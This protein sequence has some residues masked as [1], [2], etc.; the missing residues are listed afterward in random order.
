MATRHCPSPECRLI[1]TLVLELITDYSREV[2][3][4]VA[5]LCYAIS[6]D[7]SICPHSHPLSLPPSSFLP[8]F[9]SHYLSLSLSPSVI[10]ACIC[11]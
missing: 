8:P 7:R 5:F 4:H 2:C 9:I 1:V 11:L 3:V 10:T 6:A